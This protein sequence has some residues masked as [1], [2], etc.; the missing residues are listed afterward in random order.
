MIILSIPYCDP[1]AAFQ[2]FAAD[3]YVALLDGF[4]AYGE[5]RV[6][7]LAVDPDHVILAGQEGVFID[8]QQQDCDTFTAIERVMKNFAVSAVDA[9]AAPVPFV[10]GLVGAFGYELGG[11]LERLPSPKQGALRLPVLSAC[12]Y[13]TVIAFDHAAREAWIISHA[14]D[15]EAK[16]ARLAERLKDAPDYLPP[17]NWDRGAAWQAEQTR[18]VVEQSIR[19]VIDYIYAGDIFQAN[20]TQRFS[21]QRPEGLG[22]FDLYRRLRALNPAPFSAFLRCGDIALASASP[23][24]F[25]RLSADGLIQ[26]QP[27]KGTRPRNDD[28]RRDA[29][30]AD[31]LRRSAKDNAENLMIVDLMRSD[32]GRVAELGSVRVPRLNALESFAS[33]HH[34]VSTVE[35]KLRQGLSA[36]DLLRATFPGG[37]ITGAPKIRAMEII[38]ELEPSPRGFYCGCLGW[39]G[40]DGAMDMSMTIRTLTITRDKVVAQAGGG[41]V[42][43]S[44]PADEYDECMIKIAPL[45]RAVTGETGHDRLAERRIA[46]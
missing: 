25:L 32:L 17:L 11:C 46:G 3:T 42:A 14:P 9:A 29:L 18:A 44:A 36:V 19:R 15:A 2:V 1:L 20:V 41:I 16:S 12:V 40:F 8:G 37:S 6:S 26:A 38:H 7:T 22:D 30:L 31:E 39:I 28:P 24:R 4:A 5:R 21:A 35:G 23:E 43:D 33:V 27:I 34:L 13:D 10:G 45:L